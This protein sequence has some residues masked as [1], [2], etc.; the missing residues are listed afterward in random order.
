MDGHIDDP[1]APRLLFQTQGK[2]DYFD[3]I[4]PNRFMK[5]RGAERK[6]VWPAKFLLPLV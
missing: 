5:V 4:L 2:L 6:F 3:A 1:M